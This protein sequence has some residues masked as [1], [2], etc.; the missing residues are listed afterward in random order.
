MA[1][2]A[3]TVQRAQNVPHTWFATGRCQRN[4][5]KKK[6]SVHVG[7]MQ[8]AHNSKMRAEKEM[9]RQAGWLVILLCLSKNCQNFNIEIRLILMLLL[10]AATMAVAMALFANTHA[11]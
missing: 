4:M 8:S 10:V 1:A 7:K 5:I 11:F 2:M 6:K 3:L 9:H